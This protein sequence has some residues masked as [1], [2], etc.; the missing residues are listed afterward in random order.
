MERIAALARL[1]LTDSEKNKFQKELS[2]VLDYVEQLKELSVEK[3]APTVSGGEAFNAIRL[4]QSRSGDNLGEVKDIMEQ[5]PEKKD[6]FAKVRVIL[7]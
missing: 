1:Q 7:K 3:V 2:L 4:D 6:G 5:V